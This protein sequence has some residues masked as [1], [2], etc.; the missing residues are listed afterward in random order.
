MTTIFDSAA[1]RGAAFQAAEPRFVSAFFPPRSAGIASSPRQDLDSHRSRDRQGA[2]ADAVTKRLAPRLICLLAAL[3]GSLFAQP[4]PPQETHQERGKRVVEEALA[5]LGGPAFLHMEDRVETG[6]AYSFYNAQL[7]GLSVATVYTRYLAP[8]TGKLAMRERE[9]FGKKQ[10]QGFV[11]FNESGAWDVNYHGAKPLEDQRFENYRESAVLNIFYI[12][13]Q[14]LAEP[15]L[16]FYSQG[17]D[18]FENQPVE[19]VDITDGDG[20]TVTV[21]FSRSTKLPVRQSFRRRN[22]TYGDFDTETT[23]F[24]KYHSTGGI[25]WPCDIR[26]ERNGDKIFEMYSET[27]TINQTLGDEMFTLPASVKLLPK[28]K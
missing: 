22:P 7:S 15:G 14:R 16:S 9:N 17:S 21:Y 3:A 10:D 6:R 25:Q 23:G 13:R 18:R 4:A 27:V 8:E 24:A 19:I 2:A 20:R 12:L 5:A 11:L 1:A 26:R 28:D